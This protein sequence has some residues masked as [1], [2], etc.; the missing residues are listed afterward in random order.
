VSGELVTLKN[1]L[2]IATSQ[3]TS[4]LISRCG[5]HVD[6][7]HRVRGGV[8]GWHRGEQWPGSRVISAQKANTANLQPAVWPRWVDQWLSLSTANLYPA[9]QPGGSLFGLQESNL[10]DTGAAC[11][12]LFGLGTSAI[13]WSAKRSAA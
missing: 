13:R 10:V 4:G 1:A 2:E 8:H 9:V 11:W 7:R 6:R 5:N 3:Q 12:A